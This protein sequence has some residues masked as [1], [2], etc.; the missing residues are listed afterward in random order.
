MKETECAMPQITLSPE[1]FRN[2]LKV[3]E[4][5]LEDFDAVIAGLIADHAAKKYA[6][7]KVFTNGVAPD[8]TGTTLREAEIGGKPLKKVDWN[9]L[10]VEAVSQAAEK[11][12]SSEKLKDLITVKHVPGKQDGYYFV[13]SANLSIQGQNANSAWKSTERIARALHLPVKARFMWG[14]KNGN[15]GGIE[16]LTINI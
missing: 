6:S 10:M 5:K 11:V 9:A 1:T 3:C 2:L 8:L 15:P 4:E 16:T 13:P 12:S 14:P 7:P